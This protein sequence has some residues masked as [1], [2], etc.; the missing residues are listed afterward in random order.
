MKAK[1]KELILK[2]KGELK[3]SKSIK[4]VEYDD[5]H[6]GLIL[7]DIGRLESV[8]SDLERLL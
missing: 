2:Y 8:I 3:K 6:R 7:S 4:T 1:I 5:F